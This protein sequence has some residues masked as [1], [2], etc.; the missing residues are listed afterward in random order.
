MQSRREW[1]GRLL[2]LVGLAGLT[3]RGDAAAMPT[4][5]TQADTH[6]QDRPN[7]G[8]MCGVCK[9][10]IPAGGQAG[11]GMM[12]GNMGPGMIAAGACDLVDASARWAG[13]FSTDRSLPDRGPSS[14]W[15]RRR[16][17]ARLTKRP[18]DRHPATKPHVPKVKG[19]TDNAARAESH[20]A[21]QAFPDAPA[22]CA[23]CGVAGGAVGWRDKAGAFHEIDPAPLL[24][25]GLR[26]PCD[27]LAR[28]H[29]VVHVVR[30]V[31][32]ALP[33]GGNA[34]APLCQRCRMQTRARNRP[35]GRAAAERHAAMRT[36]DLF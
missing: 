12:S 6:Y 9:F 32:A 4:K 36:L 13:A 8:Q 17:K 22:R 34:P 10:Y 18:Y 15:E 25:R 23:R 1:I 5:V 14:V 30:I 3:R 20:A 21:A 2:A 27:V 28:N 31:L 7:N 16:M 24:A 29:V 11:S 26:L 33:N 35:R 19:K